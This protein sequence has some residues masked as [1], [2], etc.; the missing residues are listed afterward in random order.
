MPDFAEAISTLTIVIMVS[1]IPVYFLFLT[2][3]FKNPN[4]EIMKS[5]FFRLMFSLGMYTV[6]CGFK[7]AQKYLV[8]TCMG[9]GLGRV[10]LYLLQ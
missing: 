4:D 1:T 7:C 6:H 2:L 8:P 10:T 3:L 5:S 9:P